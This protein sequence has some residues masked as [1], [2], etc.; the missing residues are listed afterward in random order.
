MNAV[1]TPIPEPIPPSPVPRVDPEQGWPLRPLAAG[2]LVV[3]LAIAAV[4]AWRSLAPP[5]I[6]PPAPE[7]DLTS[8]LGWMF[9]ATLTHPAAATDG[10]T[11]QAPFRS[12]QISEVEVVDATLGPVLVTAIGTRPGGQPEEVTY[13]LDVRRRGQG[14]SI[15]AVPLA[16]VPVTAGSGEDGNSD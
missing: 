4:V 2:L 14:W 10:S 8:T 3:S 1:T 13:Q 15:E 9:D 11:M 12:I 16:D 7:A 6:A 5:V